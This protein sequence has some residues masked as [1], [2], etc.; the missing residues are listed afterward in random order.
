MP[1][2]IGAPAWDRAWSLPL[3]FESVRSN[4]DPEAT[5]LVFVVPPTDAATREVI[6][7]LSRDFAWTEVLRD[8]GVQSTRSDRP[9]TEHLTLAQA[10]NQVLQVVSRV[11][12]AHY[13][14][15]DT[16]YLLP[17]GAVSLMAEERVPLI[18]AWGW[19]NRK[20][21]KVIS[22]LE[23][24]QMRRVQWEDPI[25]ATAMA[26]DRWEIGKAIH[27]PAEEFV[28][29]SR[30]TWRCGVALAFQLMDRRAYMVSRYAPHHD[31]EDIPFNWLLRQRGVPRFCCGEV[32]GLHLYD[33]HAPGEIEL[34]WPGIM[35]L[36]AQKPLAATWMEPRS[37]EH[38]TFGFFE[39][40]EGAA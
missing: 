40:T 21:P 19:L 20:N 2:V 17:P 18:T 3:W 8:R 36:V 16:D 38:E 26:W 27:Y 14:S 4:V 6:A 12:P 11:Q 25:C 30:G 1:L 15:W 7:E 35:K 10:R 34:G 31:G 29:R 5:G 13:A 32:L 39:V 37:P 24:G 28:M 33:R 9:S 22:Y 23:E